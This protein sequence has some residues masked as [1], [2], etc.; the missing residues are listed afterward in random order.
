[1]LAALHSSL[2]TAIVG[3]ESGTFEEGGRETRFVVRTVAG[4][5]WRIVVAAGVAWLYTPLG[6]PRRWIPWLLFSGF[7]AAMIAAALLVVRLIESRR[8]LRASNAMLD[9]LARIDLLTDLPQEP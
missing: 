6:G 3:S 8:A 9:R 2:A 7:S 1:M 5:P 4:T